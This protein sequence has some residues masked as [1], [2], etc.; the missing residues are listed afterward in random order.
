[1][2]A[3][4][5]ECLE[6][7]RRKIFNYL[8]SERLLSRDAREF[9]AG[10]VTCFPFLHADSSMTLRCKLGNMRVGYGGVDVIGT[11]TTVFHFQPSYLSV[12][13]RI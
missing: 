2:I 12:L 8:S 11:A 10:D 1:M 4:T 3:K 5:R 6:V 9:S 7:R 13:C